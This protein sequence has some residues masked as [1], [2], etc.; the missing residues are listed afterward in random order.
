MERASINNIKNKEEKIQELS[1]YVNAEIFGNVPENYKLIETNNW[2]A[3]MSPTEK[4]EDP[5]QEPDIECERNRVIE[6]R[7]IKGKVVGYT[8]SG[9]C[10]I[11][12]PE[13][14]VKEETE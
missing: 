13:E 11:S 9:Y 14:F 8:P 2:F 3:G 6:Y 5:N 4:E 12:V 7:G 10:V 1:K